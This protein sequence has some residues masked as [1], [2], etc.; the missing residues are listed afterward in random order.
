MKN[1]VTLSL[2]GINRGVELD[3]F[4]D[5]EFGVSVFTCGDREYTIRIG[6]WFAAVDIIWYRGEA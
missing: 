1:R 6:F 3:E 4:W 2:N 5:K